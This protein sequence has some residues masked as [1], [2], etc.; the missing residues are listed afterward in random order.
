MSS[1]A[2][3]QQEAEPLAD[4]ELSLPAM[5]DH[6]RV[7]RLVGHGA[8]GQVFLGRD[9]R[10]GRRVAIK[11]IHPDHL[12][13]EGAR[14]R[15][16]EEARTTAKFS[17]PNIVTIYAVGQ[18]DGSPYLAMEFLEGENLRKRIDEERE[19]IDV[20]RVGLAIAS[21]LEEAHS[22]GVVHRDLK[23]ENVVIPQ[24]GRPRVLDFGLA[25]RRIPSLP[26]LGDGEAA[27]RAPR[28]VGTPAYMAPEQWR[29]GES[30]P[31]ADIWALGVMLYELLSGQRPYA[32][33]EA[34][35]ERLALRVSD[36]SLV[37]EVDA[38]RR[39]PAEQRELVQSCLA[40]DPEMRPSAT[41]VVAGLKK[42][43]RRRLDVSSEARCPF[44]GLQPFGEA[45]APFF[46]GRDVELDAFFERLRVE[47]F[48]PIVGPSGAGKS[49]F[50]RAGVIPRLRERTRWIVLDVTPGTNPYLALAA[51]LLPQ[52]AGAK[53]ATGGATTEDHGDAEL[54]WDDVEAE[55][56]RQ[57]ERPSVPRDSIAF[58]GQLAEELAG[59]Q[60]TLGR[61][62]RELADGSAQVLLFV[63]QLEELCTLVEDGSSRRAFVEMLSAAADDP[64]EPVRLI[65]TLRDD[66]LGRLA[67]GERAREA[68]SRVTVL[69]APS[70]RTLEET[71]TR[72][73]EATGYRFLPAKLAQRMVEAVRG[74]A[75]ALPL[76]QFTARLLWEGRDQE[77]RALTEAVYDSLGGVEG[78]LAE[79][80]DGVLEG[81]TPAQVTVARELLLGLITAE[82]T[83][84][85]ISR[86]ALLSE[87]E[88][89]TEDGESSGNE[90]VLD[91][92]IRARLVSVRRSLTEDERSA[93]LELAHE[94]LIR[95]W[96][97]LSRW[98]D[99]SREE[100]AFL[101]QVTQAAE[102]WL[103]R[104]RSEEMAWEGEPLRDALRDARKL[105]NLPP[106][107]A[108]FL[109]AG[110]ARERRGQRR[111]RAFLAALITLLALVA[112]G[113]TIGAF[114]L[115]EK[116]EEAQRQRRTAERQTQHAQEQ[117]AEALREGARAAFL[118]GE[119]VLARAMLRASLEERVSSLGRGLWWQLAREPLQ[120][121]RVLGGDIDAVAFS[122]DG[123]LVAAVGDAPSVFLFRVDDMT[124]R[125]LRGHRQKPDDLA[126]SPDGRWLASTSSAAV[127]RVWRLD[128]DS[129]EPVLEREDAGGPLAFDAAGSLLATGHR[130]G[131]VRLW[132]FPVTSADPVR[133]LGDDETEQ[134]PIAAVAVDSEGARIAAGTMDGRVRVWRR[135][136]G[137]LERE[138]RA[139]EFPVLSLAFHPE[140]QR[141]A[142]ASSDAVV[143]LWQ[144]DEGAESAPVHEVV[145]PDA[146]RDIAFDSEGERLVA[147]TARGLLHVWSVEAAEELGRFPTGDDQV[148][149]L[150][151]SPDGRLVAAGGTDGTLRLYGLARALEAEEDRGHTAAALGTALSPDGRLV[152]TG[153]ND[154]TVRLWSVE[155]GR[156]LSVLR[157]KTPS[158]FTG[159]VFSKNGEQVIAAG[160]D[161]ALRRWDTATGRQLRTP[162]GPASYLSA[163][164]L[165]PVDGDVVTAGF[166][167]VLRS[168]SSTSGEPIEELARHE[169]WVTD[170]D[171]SADGRLMASGGHDRAVRVW[172][173]TGAG[174]RL[175]RE[176]TALPGAVHGL[177]FDPSGR[178]LAFAL[179]SEAVRW[180]RLEDDEVEAVGETGARVYWLDV[181]PDGRRLG[182]PRDDGTAQILALD[183]RPTVLLRGHLGEVNYLRFSRDGAFAATTSDDGTVRL[184][185]VESG[186]S[187]WWAPAL[188]RDAPQVYSQRG[189]TSFAGSFE[190]SAPLSDWRNAIERDARLALESSDGAVG[191]LLNHDGELRLWALGDEERVLR[192]VDQR[193]S[194]ILAVD[195]GCVAL[196]G[197]EVW[198][199]GPDEGATSRVLRAGV[200]AIASAPGGQLLIADGREVQLISLDE[201]A[202]PR[203]RVA[204]GGWVTAMLAL[205]DG[206][207]VGFG[208]GGLELLSFSQDDASRAFSFE[209][210]PASPPTALALGPSD[211]LV[212]GFRNGVVGLWS[213]LNGSSLL[214]FRLHGPVRHLDVVEDEL[215]VVTEL[216]DTRLIDV[217]A[218]RLGRCELLRELWRSVP[219]VWS[220]GAPARRP[221]PR[222][223][224]CARSDP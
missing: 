183:G 196:Q 4:M 138:L 15:F 148:L 115:A 33:Q 38:I 106:L 101:E 217:G 180:W 155:S 122:P 13:A 1:T 73:L 212:A 159:V 110:R 107:V 136:T 190:P 137:R 165:D 80:A 27:P 178:A 30:G 132:A 177:R 194:S 10:L 187:L 95:G 191:C 63:D 69:R 170:V 76:I 168:W 219:V 112:V 204:T 201:G 199:H 59:S 154:Q 223:H 153:S 86:S 175:W 2:K 87:R 179:G 224:P 160:T 134:S 131:R 8:M 88:P 207:V 144:L 176:R 172:D 45:Q 197:D 109:Q 52:L 92:L 127:L 174:P 169:A 5:V 142:A 221:P 65:V 149:T 78:A 46:F 128:Q 161:G 57:S 93:E 145:Y 96:E 6:F 37:P 44:P 193:P 102:L 58:A 156:Q 140:G 158:R 218:L 53:D 214:R 82:G 147:G 42:L 55:Q 71:L 89:V 135:D 167:G 139:T 23:P 81:M 186:R 157:G 215:R 97:R 36:G 163:L 222:Q 211:T 19:N 32:G 20:L 103:E 72:P 200:E 74:E 108:D 213:V 67:E 75:A 68:L 206:V 166:D 143:R 129:T 84:R 43:R 209:G 7:T 12:R 77:K 182:L 118:R 18:H 35:I 192:E 152:A 79:H 203:T 40:K 114:A 98:F 39:L 25:V 195:S 31:A 146:V 162:M 173:M 100:L 17:H 41:E 21:A 11:V 29:R 216:G 202:R 150:A 91:R 9:E 130:D 113:S 123:E 99:A 14:E 181:H 83:R 120:W 22:H 121:R 34:S 210:L 104:G 24:D 171:F 28:R 47:P 85:V 117:S 48:L 66:F 208:D 124:A 16:I 126:F 188:L 61:L 90:E 220:E 51:A 198:L 116:E 141:L 133:I 26:Q 64:R 94:S 164:A 50:V 60:G 125:A 119:H 111:R 3:D 70:E 54:D 151:L 185:D 49:S 62:L 189:W 56:G 105:P 184:W 205:D